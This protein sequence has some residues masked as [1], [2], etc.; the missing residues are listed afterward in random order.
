MQLLDGE[1]GAHVWADRLDTDRRDLAEAQSEITWPAARMLNTELIGDVGRRIEQE[2]GADP[3]A[4]DLV[5]RARALYMQG[6]SSE[7][8]KKVLDLSE[9]A[10]AID[11][12]SVDARIAIEQTLAANISDN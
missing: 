11:R 1:S 8:N 5:M 10:L 12:D 7:T 4:R 3:D 2:R 6:F 9:R